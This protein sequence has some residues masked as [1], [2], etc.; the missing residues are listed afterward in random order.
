MKYILLGMSRLLSN[1][2]AAHRPTGIDRVVM[3]YLRHYENHINGV[4]QFKLINWKLNLLLSK[5]TTS[6]ILQLID[7]KPKY[8]R[9]KIILLLIKE[10]ITKKE[11][12]QLAG[13][14]LLN[15]EP[16]RYDGHPHISNLPGV[17]SLFM[18]HDLIP[19][20]YPEYCSPGRAQEYLDMFDCL[21]AHAHGILTNSKSTLE[22][23]QNFALSQRKQL[24]PARAV[25]LG[26]DLHLN[27]AKPSNVPPLSQPYF[28]ILGT[29]E[30]RKNHL[31]LLQVWRRLVEELQEKTPRLVII[32]QRGWELENIVDY[33]ERCEILREF[34]IE[35]LVNDNELVNYLCHARALLFPTFAEGY[36]MPL[37][38]ALSLKVPVIAS[39]LQVFKEIARD[40]P[41][42]ID[43][44]DGLTWLNMIKA[45]TH[46]NS[47][48]RLSQLQ[49]LSN[50][51]PPTWA[52]HFAKLDAFMESLLQ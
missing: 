21:I 46:E 7:A 6:Q 50:Y 32:G 35:V 44:L 26:S 18:V 11:K 17:I 31:L 1:A 39:N 29:I 49:R 34:V 4:V 33:L 3:A 30:P 45:Y 28:V 36:G 13:G 38:E 5:N 48:Q 43:P 23:L 24:P 16:A 10:R 25:L 2:I 37:A 27:F 42:Y 8:F 52:E 14:V 41:E 19:L 40:I 47:E 20:H 22:E 51:T 9:F 15:I 12:Q